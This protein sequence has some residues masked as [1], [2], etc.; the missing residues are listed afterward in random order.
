MTWGGRK[1]IKGV[2]RCPAKVRK[3]IVELSI[4]KEEDIT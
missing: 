2:E 3:T 1:E 4:S